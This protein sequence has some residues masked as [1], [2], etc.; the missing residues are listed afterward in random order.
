MAESS[1][2]LGCFVNPPVMWI[3]PPFTW[4]I[5]DSY[6]DYLTKQGFKP[7]ENPP[8]I[9]SDNNNGLSAEEKE[10]LLHL[11]SAWNSFQKLVEKHS[12]DDAE[13]LK[14]IHDAQKMIALRVA[15]R[16]DKDV[17]AQ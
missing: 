14:A 16:I 3:K 6:Y 8:N 12:S 1:V 2:C 11:V 9:T 17:W 7:I 13:F 5:I 10:C 4:N 15:R